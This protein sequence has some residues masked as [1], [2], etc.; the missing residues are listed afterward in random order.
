MT[1]KDI[2][3]YQDKREALK[4]IGE[5]KE[6]ARDFRDK[7]GTTDREAIDLLNGKNELA[8]LSK[9]ES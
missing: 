6:L 1:S 2:R 9:Y 8:I 5:F 3:D 4:T 7:F